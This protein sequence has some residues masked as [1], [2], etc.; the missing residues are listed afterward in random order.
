ML[1]VIGGEAPKLLASLASKLRAKPLASLLVGEAP[2]L[3]ASLASELRA[4]PLALFLGAKREAPK[5]L[6]SL[7]AEL[8]AKPVASFLEGEARSSAATSFTC[9]KIFGKLRAIPE[10]NLAV[11]R[12]EVIGGT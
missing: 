1:G 10:P 3:L 9:F 6:A 2:R 11:P 4:K 7:A 12:K 5:L 8:R